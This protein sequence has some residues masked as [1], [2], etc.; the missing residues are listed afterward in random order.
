MSVK[1]DVQGTMGTRG[2]IQRLIDAWRQ[3]HPEVLDD[4][5]IAIV[6]DEQ[7]IGPFGTREEAGFTAFRQSQKGGTVRVGRLRPQ[8]NTEATILGVT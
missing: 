6:N 1:H 5:F 3:L 8:E 2:E 4:Q 7:V